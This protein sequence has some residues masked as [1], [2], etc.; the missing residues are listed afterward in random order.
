MV[1][2]IREGVRRII[3]L[4]PYALALFRIALGLLLLHDCVDR[5]HNLTAHYTR[6]GIFPWSA[7]FDSSGIRSWSLNALSGSPVYQSFLFGLA[8][9]AAILIIVGFKTRPALLAAWLWLLSLDHFNPAL[10]HTSDMVFRLVLFW[11]IWLPTNSRLA[12]DAWR[13]PHDSSVEHPWMDRMAGAGLVTQIFL[14]YVCAAL[15]KDL[16]SWSFSGN[17]AGWS[18]LLDD[19]STPL[20]VK[21]QQFPAL[22]GALTVCIR[23]IEM[24]AP[25]LLIFPFP[26]NWARA[27]GLLL[28][29]AM[30]VGMAVCLNLGMFPYVCLAGLIAL[31][32]AE[33]MQKFPWERIEATLKGIYDR[34]SAETA[35][36]FAASGKRAVPWLLTAWLAVVTVSIL[37]SDLHT[38]HLIP[39]APL[40]PMTAMMTDLGLNQGWGMFN[41]PGPSGRSWFIIRARLKDGSEIDLNNSGKPLSWDPPAN[42]SEQL[43]SNRWHT[44]WARVTG[45]YYEGIVN[46][47]YMRDS[48]QRYADFLC[49]RG[50]GRAPGEGPVELEFAWMK[51]P[52]SD[53]NS[54]S[55][56]TLLKTTCPTRQ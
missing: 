54:I 42:P 1:T 18:L 38:V 45:Q 33:M 35:D 30:H 40:K 3:Q 7:Y 49:T 8:I 27:L 4:D 44:Y 10:H 56:T 19:Y 14:M 22:T 5:L 15:S 34:A 32:P 23:H 39:W 2:Q 12:I 46:D 53:R 41:S 50:A 16:A 9:I 11:A 31:L 20:G 48:L 47:S 26:G 37:W 29:M 13:L 25:F 36:R 28:L 43:T 55:R 51:S 17:A 24:Y 21:L 52:V 6:Y